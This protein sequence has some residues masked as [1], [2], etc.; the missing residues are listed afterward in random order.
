[1]LHQNE[2][3]AVTKH[4]SRKRNVGEL[5]IDSGQ[6]GDQ[7]ELMPILIEGG[8]VLYADTRLLRVLDL[9]EVPSSIQSLLASLD[10]ALATGLGRAYADAQKGPTISPWTS[11][12]KTLQCRSIGKTRVDGTLSVEISVRRGGDIA[13]TS[14]S[15]STGNF[16]GVVERM[17]NIAREL[18]FAQTVIDGLPA[19]F[20]L[21]NSNGKII[22]WN[23]YFQTATAIDQDSVCKLSFDDLFRENK[24]STLFAGDLCNGP[25][26]SED[27]LV[28]ESGFH[29]PVQLS[30][31]VVAFG[32]D[33]F[34]VL[35]AHD[36]RVQKRIERQLSRAAY[37]DALTRLPNRARFVRTLQER[38]D[39][40]QG[41][42]AMML[43]DV[44]HFRS[45]ND[46]LGEDTG[47]KLLRSLATRLRVATREHD[48]LARFGA[49]E[50]AVMLD[51]IESDEQVEEISSR[52]LRV[53]GTMFAVED[54]R[55]TLSA[56]V[57]IVADTSFSDRAEDIVRAAESALYRA[58]ERGTAQIVRY[59]VG[60]SEETH[61]RLELLSE[62]RSA[63][64]S[65]ELRMYLQPIFSSSSS[66]AVGFEALVRWEHPR[67]GLLGPE[68]FVDLAEASGVIGLIDEWML[69]RA[70]AKL[71]EWSACPE[72]QHLWISVN[73]SPRTLVG[74]SL[75]G[76]LAI[77]EP[78]P[79]QIVSRLRVELTETALLG[80]ENIALERLNRLKK[81]GPKIIL[82]DFGAG[83]SSL[84][85][86]QRFPIDGLKVDRRFVDAVAEQG[87]ET[88][89]VSTLIELARRLDLSI[90]AEGVESQLQYD[91]LRDM[92]CELQQGYLMGV[93]VDATSSNYSPKTMFIRGT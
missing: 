56:C 4:V 14:E 25:Y 32:C 46:G 2:N 29:L 40:G 36:L 26:R 70:L 67:L 33:T 79:P 38:L 80:D 3:P 71:Q 42:L 34:L 53:F 92:G 12:G 5:A 43:I 72:T 11:M 21:F 37:F 90:T 24:L 7:N 15:G 64:D 83:Y 65:D 16:F 84:T 73:V 17:T 59:E 27:S 91:C 62:L 87:R 60:M 13:Q 48:Y 63:V 66:S 35:S 61:R 82:D 10:P 47:N 81:L 88:D 89:M 68:K 1:M 39:R 44:D 74:K 6:I 50:F 86:L 30:I 22:R 49:D 54:S 20:A 57:G 45:I 78:T 52:L 8:D 51:G 9:L 76:Y 31:E 69:V 85:H 23:R 19:M 41:S 77:L 18:Q 75:D 58:K 28:T 55:I 93:P